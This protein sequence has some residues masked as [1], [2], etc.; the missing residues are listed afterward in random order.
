M[1]NTSKITYVIEEN[2]EEFMCKILKVH[3][4]LIMESESGRFSGRAPKENLIPKSKNNLRESK[5]EPLE[6]DHEIEDDE[7]KM[8]EKQI[9]SNKF[10][11]DTHLQE[12]KD[13]FLN[14][15]AVYSLK[16]IFN[17]FNY[18]IHLQNIKYLKK[19]VLC[20]NFEHV[21][22]HDIDYLG[23]YHKLIY[24]LE[25]EGM[26]VYISG[27]TR[28][29]ISINKLISANKWIMDKYSQGKI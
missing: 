9:V 6:V 12:L 15:G 20:I 5:A 11:P 28:Q 2:L 23:D 7:E 16:G 13:N 27:W 24:R 19:D 4:M 3:K 14:F 10:D 22:R 25:Q 18:R 21:W 29:E 26:D 17:F 1:Q 8:I